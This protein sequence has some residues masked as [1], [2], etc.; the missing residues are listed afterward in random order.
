[1][2]TPQAN[3]SR[4]M[5]PFQTSYTLYLNRQ[6]RRSGHV[7][8]QRYMTFLVDKDNYFLQV[9]RYIHRNPLEAKLV[10]RPQDYRWAATEL[11]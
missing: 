4:V 11:M 10:E 8:E 5:Q 3:L 1:M 2:E 9:S 6:H 7:F